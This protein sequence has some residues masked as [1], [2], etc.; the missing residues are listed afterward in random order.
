MLRPLLILDGGNLTLTTSDLDR[1]KS[2]EWTF[3]DQVSNGIVEW[4]D[5]EEEEDLL[6][7]ARPF[8]LPDVSPKHGRPMNPSKVEWVNLG[9]PDSN[10]AHLKVEVLM[11][12]GSAEIEE[13]NLP[14]NYHQPDIDSLKRKERKERVRSARQ[15]V[16]TPYTILDSEQLY[17]R[18]VALAEQYPKSYAVS[19]H[20]K[21]SP[22]SSPTG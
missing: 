1:L 16:V 4:V 9:D 21:V 13:F 5:A 15:K 18:M 19:Y 2:G 8:D 7:A 22:Y 12:D 11:P 3:N 17:R 14:L 10:E 6:I 20:V